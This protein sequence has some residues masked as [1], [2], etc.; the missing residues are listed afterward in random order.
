MKITLTPM[1]RDD[2]L[3]LWRD[4]D[5]LTVN[6]ESL[7]F[8]PLKE[9]ALLPRDAVDCAWIA[10]D[11]ERRGG[12][13]CLALILPHGADAPVQTRHPAPLHLTED[14]PV[15]LPP[16]ELTGADHVED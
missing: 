15:A 13:I 12:E 6:G 11:V 3:T 14:G 1:R 10:S 7:D 9:G 2:R 4:G 5:V 16:Y 8:G